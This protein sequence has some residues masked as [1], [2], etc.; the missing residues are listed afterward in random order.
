V[1]FDAEDL[2]I[3]DLPENNF[4]LGDALEQIIKINYE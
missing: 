3:S 2:L 1:H 4:L